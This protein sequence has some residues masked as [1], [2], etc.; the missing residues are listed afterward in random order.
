MRV[1]QE[2]YHYTSL[3]CSII[4]RLIMHTFHAYHTVQKMTASYS[5]IPYPI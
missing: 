5:S 2:C 3:G 1:I 4:H